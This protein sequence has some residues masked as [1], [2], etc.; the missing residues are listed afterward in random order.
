MDLTMADASAVPDLRPGDAALLLGDA[1]GL[2]ADDVAGRSG[3]IAYE[4]LTGIRSR[5]AR[6]PVRSAPDVERESA[7]ASEA[8]AA[9]AEPR[10]G[11]P[12]HGA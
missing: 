2:T 4:I 7:D 8:R 3:A 1:T 10:A 11:A 9:A 5:V 12:V 6:R